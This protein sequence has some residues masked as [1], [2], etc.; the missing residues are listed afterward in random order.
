MRIYKSLFYSPLLTLGLFVSFFTSF[1]PVALALT[2]LYQ[3]PSSLAT[4]AAIEAVESCKK[5]GYNVTATIVNSEGNTQVIIRGDGATPH[6]LPN[7]FNKAF[8]VITLAP[9]T[10]VDSTEEI[11][12]KMT[13]APLPVG[14]LPLA[15]EPLKGISFSTGGVAIKVGDQIVG[16][17]GVSGSPG[18]GLDQT[19]AIRG[20]EKIKPR[21]VP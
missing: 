6:T 14:S 9:I 10:K 20:I 15:P 11:A 8:T 3:L 4:E 16:A 19:C 2:A 1:S 21:L 18:G 12:K 5:D 17:I 7:S 13:P